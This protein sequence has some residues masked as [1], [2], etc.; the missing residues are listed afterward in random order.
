MDMNIKV[1]MHM[2]TIHPSQVQPTYALAEFAASLNYLDLPAEVI[3]VTKCMI[4]DSIGTALAATTLGDGCKE[5]VSIMRDLSG[6]P[7]CRILGTRE[8]VSA[9]NAAFANGALVHA[10][11]YD[12]IGSHVGHLGVVCLAAPLAMAEALGGVTG[13]ELLAASV[14]ACEITARVTAAVSYTGRPLSD[15][16]LPGQILSYFGATAGAA[17]ILRLD[18]EKM[19]S[20]FGL[21]LMQAA[22]SR[23]VVISGVPAKAIYGAFPNQAGVLAAMLAERGLQADCDVLGEPAGLLE[24][25]YGG[26]YDQGVLLGGLGTEFLLRDVSFKRWPTSGH[27]HPFI[28]AALAIRRGGLQPTD[29]AS[30]ETIAHSSVRDWCEPVE[31]RRRPENSA[32]AANSIPFCVAKALV[33][34]DVRLSD[35]TRDGLQDEQAI[36]IAQRTNYSLDDS[37]DGGV[38]RVKIRDGRTLEAHGEI[39][40]GYRSNPVDLDQLAEKFRDCCSHS[41]V[42]LASHQVEALIAAIKGLER[43]EDISLITRLATGE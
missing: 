8:K 17:R 21:G 41:A 26:A 3:D 38:V 37:V 6:K 12:P 39:P 42:P 29:I 10:L 18:P 27:V 13:R 11:N 33:R 14:V 7:E 5:S 35:V 25:V 43:V 31:K 4:L 16:H 40:K 1:V 2:E 15:K 23:Q 19:R 22:G 30:V 36:G 28:E 20:A 9:P 24:M 32:A 34:G